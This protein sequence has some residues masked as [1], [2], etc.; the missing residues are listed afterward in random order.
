MTQMPSLRAVPATRTASRLG[1]RR[2]GHDR[3]PRSSIVR[4]G[5]HAGERRARPRTRLYASGGQAPGRD[6]ALDGPDRD[7]QPVS[8]LL[9]VSSA[10][11]TSRLS[12]IALNRHSNGVRASRR[13]PSG[14]PGHSATCAA[15]RSG[16]PFPRRPRSPRPR[17]P[18][19]ATSPRGRPRGR[20][21]EARRGSHRFARRVRPRPRRPRA[22]A[23]CAGH[24]RRRAARRWERRP[25]VRLADLRGSTKALIT[26]GTMPSLDSV[27]PNVASAVATT[28]SAT[29]QSPIPPPSAAPGRGP[30]RAP[31]RRRSR[32]T[33]PASPWRPARCPRP[34]TRSRRAST[35]CRT[36]AECASGAGEDARTQRLWR[37]GAQPLEG[38]VQLRDERRVE[39]VTHV[40]A[41]ERDA[42]ERP[43]A[44]DLER[45]GHAE[46]PRPRRT[47]GSATA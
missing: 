46:R 41:I 2:G 37:L 26:A 45:R 7:A 17:R 8:D 33:S 32:R 16:A 39:R 24:D 25:C 43:I 35:Q 6:P 36:R 44:L 5:R 15:A 27:K 30:P 3:G 47:N 29:A 18:R 21:L 28:T 9:G 20:T 10:S 11:S 42:G 40:R 1:S 14:P 13:T 34:T 19:T 23:R 12:R 38:G 31:G 4:A 22:R